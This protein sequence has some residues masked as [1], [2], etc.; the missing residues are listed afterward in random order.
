VKLYVSCCAW[1]VRKAHDGV[2]GLFLIDYAAR[3]ILQR[4]DCAI[5][6]KAWRS[7][8]GVTF[9]K[10]HLYAARPIDDRCD[11]VV[12]FDRAILQ[13]IDHIVLPD[14]HDI[15]QIDLFDDL[16]W[17]TNTNYHQVVVLDPRTRT[18]VAR[19]TV[20]PGVPEERHLT[21]AKRKG[22]GGDYRQ[23][24][25]INSLM[26]SQGKV[27]LGL[28]GTQQGDF[29]QS[30][31]LELTWERGSDGAI[32]FSSA[33][34]VPVSGFR[35]P[36][37]VHVRADGTVL[38]CASAEGEFR[39]GQRKLQLNGWPRGIAVTPDEFYVAISSYSY[40]LASKEQQTNK[41]DAKAAIVRIDRAT[42]QVKDRFEFD[43][44]GQ[45]F[46]VRL[47]EECDYGM[48]RYHHLDPRHAS[49]PVRRSA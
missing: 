9:D 16:L 42:M 25:H 37:N 18:V 47:A 31:L 12:V 41:P 8:N 6:P 33:R 35:Y 38:G 45:L 19:H 28:F 36:H 29:G 10:D 26:V 27:Q 2:A 13:P 32:R 44:I 22:G 34:P 3:K 20:F 4:H 43:R 48:S 5:A 30:Q 7:F 40:G 15:H 1:G 49:G 24:P 39:Y 11:E 21:E 23:R 14:C 17:L 46:E